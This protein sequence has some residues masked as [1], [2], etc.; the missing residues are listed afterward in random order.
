[1]KK[2]FKWLGFG[3]GGLVVAGL[4][5]AGLVQRRFVADSETVYQPKA[6]EIQSLVRQADVQLGRRIYHVRAGCV[7]CHGADLAGVKVLD[8]PGIG[9]VFGANISP[10]NLASWSDEEI[11]R[12]GSKG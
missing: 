6:F 7:D 1:M 9:F 10:A 11:A 8:D 4:G 12:E 3:L 5:F 2:A